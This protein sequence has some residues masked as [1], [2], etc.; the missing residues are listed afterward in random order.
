MPTATRAV[1]ANV[2]GVD[3]TFLPAFMSFELDG[4]GVS[5]DR[6]LSMLAALDAHGIHTKGADTVRARINAA[7]GI[8]P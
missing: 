5:R 8:E 2:Y 6:M 4:V 3:P 1:A 7:L